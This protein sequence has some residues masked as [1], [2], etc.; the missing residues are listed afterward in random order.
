MEVPLPPLLLEPAE[1][2]SI[3][4]GLLSL[5]FSLGLALLSFL[6]RHP[7]AEHDIRTSCRGGSGC[8]CCWRPG[9]LGRLHVVAARGGQERPEQC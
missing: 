6:H 7:G 4:A 9:L 1:S 2:Y 5:A 3:M 8:H